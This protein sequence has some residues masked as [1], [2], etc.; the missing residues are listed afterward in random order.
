MQYLAC[1]PLKKKSYFSLDN[2]VSISPVFTGTKLNIFSPGAK[3]FR[4]PA[5]SLGAQ[6]VVMPIN[7]NLI[8]NIVK[9]NLKGHYLP[10]SKI[11]VTFLASK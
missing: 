11:F 10:K 4:G 1:L 6:P 7:V 8:C 5:E 2:Q 3:N 9:K